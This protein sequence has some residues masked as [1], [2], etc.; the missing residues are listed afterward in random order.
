MGIGS[1][2]HSTTDFQWHCLCNVAVSL[3]WRDRGNFPIRLYY[4]LYKPTVLASDFNRTTSSAD[5]LLMDSQQKQCKFMVIQPPK[6]SIG[7]IKAEPFSSLSWVRNYII[8]MYMVRKPL[9]VRYFMA[10]LFITSTLIF[11]THNAGEFLDFPLHITHMWLFINNE[12]CLWGGV[13]H[14][15]I[16]KLYHH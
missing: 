3:V 9:Y 5:D 2:H 7:V 1:V 4:V 13:S 15:Y 8:H 12:L 10:L 14:I 6:S 11:S 16:S